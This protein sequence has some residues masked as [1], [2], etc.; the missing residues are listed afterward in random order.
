MSV[1]EKEEIEKKKYRYKASAFLLGIGGK[2]K[3]I[4]GLFPPI[5]FLNAC[6]RLTMWVAAVKNSLKFLIM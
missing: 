6:Y 3:N 4:L 5:L 1:E 2:Y